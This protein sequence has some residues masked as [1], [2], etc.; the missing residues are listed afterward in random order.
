M[1][2]R[3]LL[4][5]GD[6]ARR[7]AGRRTLVVGTLATP[8]R[9]SAENGIVCPPYHH[10]SPT[11]F[12]TYACT[13]CY[14]AGS[15]STLVAPVVKVF[16]NLE[17]TLAAIGRRARRLAEPT[18]FYVGKLQDGLSLDPLTGFSR[19]LVPF[20]AAS[21][22]ARGVVLTKSDAVGNLFGLDHRGHTALSWSVNPPDVCRAHERGTP[23]LE[24]RLAAARRCHDAG[25]PV[26]FLIMPILPVDDWEAKY[27]GLVDRLFETVRPQ[28]ITLGGICSYGTALRLT[29]KALGPDNVVARHLA[30]EASPDGRRRYAPELRERLYRHVLAAIR[31]HDSRTPVA[32]CLEEESVWRALG[33]DPASSPCN[34]V[35]G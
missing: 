17:D 1:Q 34:C 2:L 24:R 30:Q 35:W 3:G 21:E 8:L 12:C 19:V 22:V 6:D 28:R 11:G 14:L 32:L 9:R 29:A 23:T 25:Y 27:S 26:R 16:L 13:Y 15:C 20:F 10:I 7:R 18:S 33:L 5:A 4:P 31:R